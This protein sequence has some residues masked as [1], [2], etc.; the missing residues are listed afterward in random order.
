M[1]NLFDVKNK[2]IVITGGAGILGRGMDRWNFCG[3]LILQIV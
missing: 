1:K 3:E 2:V